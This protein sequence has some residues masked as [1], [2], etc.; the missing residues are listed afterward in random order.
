MGFVHIRLSLLKIRK[1]AIKD[2][3][4]LCLDNKEHTPKIGDTLAQ[5][6]I[7]D[8]PLEVQ[9]VNAS[10]SAVI[11]SDIKGALQ[12]IFSQI[13]S[14]NELTR[15]RCFKYIA[16]KV[17]TIGPTVL[18][19]EIEDFIIQ[20]IKKIL[21]DVTA[22]EFH[23][24]M[25][26][27]GSTKLGTTITGHA[28]MVNIAIEQ[29][30]LGAD[31]DAVTIEDEVVERFIQCASAVLPYFSSTIKSTPFVVFVCDK[32][33]PITTWNMIT[34][35]AT[36]DQVQLRLLKVFAEMS[37]HCEAF[38][39]NAAK[40]IENVYNI[41]REYMPAPKL[42]EDVMASNPSFE[43]SHIECLLFALHTLGKKAPDQ[44]NFITDPE[45]LKDFRARLQFLAR[46]TQGYIKKLEEAVKGK[47]EEDLKTEENKMKLTALKTTS[48][49]SALIRDLFHTPPSFKTSVQLSWVE[50][51]IKTATKRHTQITFGDKSGANGNTTAANPKRAKGGAGHDQKVYTPPSGKFS[52]KSHSYGNN[53]RNN[54]RNNRGGGGGGGS[55][56]GFR[57]NNRRFKRY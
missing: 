25:K 30:E 24:C 31:I 15:E 28:E 50:G 11:K 3:P 43:F 36:Q 17:L 39:E 6:L 23:L 34:T 51:T 53:N 52:N 44:L 42:D 41:L 19:K 13:T 20:E 16:A 38:E 21:Q 22:D 49:I 14:G 48:N 7:L 4:K 57:N 18:T 47:K 56:N 27:L 46:G 40:R 54:N 1:Q 5:L 2:L 10:L 33:F 32:L 45:K 55:G 37:P 29:A 12:G 26:I 35:A 9:Q 8:E